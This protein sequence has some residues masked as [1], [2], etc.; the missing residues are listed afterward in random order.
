MLS[1]V[2]LNERLKTLN[3]GRRLL[4]SLLLAVLLVAG[5]F[6]T[7]I[8]GIAVMVALADA[9]VGGTLVFP[10]DI[11]VLGLP[12]LMA[13]LAANGL[14]GLAGREGVA[15]GQTIARVAVRALRSG[16]IR[17]FI[18]GALSGVVWA[19]VIHRDLLLY[20]GLMGLSIA[21]AYGLFGAI[22]SV[23]EPLCLRL[24]NTTA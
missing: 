18:I 10:E 24:V 17:G 1:D 5:F 16:L 7:I 4:Y 21:L 8:L 19:L 2:E 11:F 14:V 20:G 23:A 15:P 13:F 3:I 22:T 12:V 9:L 6:L